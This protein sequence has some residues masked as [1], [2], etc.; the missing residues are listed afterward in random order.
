[1]ADT[2]LKFRM[3]PSQLEFHDRIVKGVLELLEPNDD[4]APYFRNGRLI[5]HMDC[6]DWIGSYDAVRRVILC[7]GKS[8]STLSGFARAYYKTKKHSAK[9]PNGWEECE[10]QQDDGTWRR[11]NLLK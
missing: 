7:R 4:L 5:R 1:M 10:Y 8:Y 3:N 6:T 9:R 2:E 11:V